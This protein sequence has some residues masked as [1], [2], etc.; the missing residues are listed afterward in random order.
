MT[1]SQRRIERARCGQEMPGTSG[2]GLDF[3]IRRDDGLDFEL[4]HRGGL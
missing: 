1:M 3:R 2:G 4:R